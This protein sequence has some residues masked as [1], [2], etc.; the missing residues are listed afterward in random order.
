MGRKEVFNAHPEGFCFRV[1]WNVY[2]VYT[3]FQSPVTG[4]VLKI[5]QCYKPRAVTGKQEYLCVCFSSAQGP[6]CELGWVSLVFC[7]FSLFVKGL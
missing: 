2:I 3:S 5:S 1:R 6:L 7:L 4:T